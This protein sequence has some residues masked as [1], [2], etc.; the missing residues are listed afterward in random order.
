MDK[1]KAAAAAAAAAEPASPLSTAFRVL[2]VGPMRA[3]VLAGR[4]DLVTAAP[5]RSP[6]NPLGNGSSVIPPGAVPSGGMKGGPQGLQGGSQG[7]PGGSSAAA[8]GAHDTPGALRLEVGWEAEGSGWGVRCRI[9]SEPAL[10]PGPLRALEEMAEAGEEQLWLDAVSVCA[11]PL[12]ILSEAVGMDCVAQAGLL[13]QDVFLTQRRPPYRVDLSIQQVP[14]P[15]HPLSWFLS[16]DIYR[17][18]MVKGGVKTLVQRPA[19]RK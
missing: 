15:A 14:F 19:E 7:G 17:A 12:V 18:E 6:G 1:G 16:T 8:L 10:P 9:R 3:C 13:P 11:E 2:S 5:L 4:S